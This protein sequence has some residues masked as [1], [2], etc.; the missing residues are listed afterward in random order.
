MSVNYL[1]RRYMNPAFNQGWNLFA[2]N[3]PEKEKWTRYRY[4]VD[5][6]WS[7]WHRTDTI[8]QDEFH[9]YRL[10]HHVKV[11]HVV[12]NA[13]AHLWG[14]A[15]KAGQMAEDFYAE[16]Q[17]DS[18]AYLKDAFGY[19]VSAHLIHS[20]EKNRGVS[21]DS[22]QMQLILKDPFVLEGEEKIDTVIY[23]FPIK[24]YDN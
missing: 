1:G 10:T 7:D 20:W 8:Y 24:T 19:N 12:Q 13:S 23:D 2:P 17:G 16:Y 6:A 15:W 21:M 4:A 14:E 22:L 11:H 3:P 9:Q 18:V 5:G